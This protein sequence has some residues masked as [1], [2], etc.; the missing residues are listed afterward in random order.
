MA[1]SLSSWSNGGNAG[2]HRCRPGKEPVTVREP[3][4]ILVVP[5]SAIIHNFG[6]DS[7]RDVLEI[8]RNVGLN[9]LESRSRDDGND[10]EEVG[11]FPEASS[12]I[13]HGLRPGMAVGGS[14][15]ILPQIDAIC[16][17]C[18]KIW[19]LGH[20]LPNCSPPAVVPDPHDVFLWA[21]KKD[22]MTD[23]PPDGCTAIHLGSLEAGLRVLL[24]SVV[25]RLITKWNISLV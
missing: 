17:R 8:I 16:V 7:S 15:S 25:S 20:D 19:E 22:E 6:I 1:E 9:D 21:P 13:I 14:W 4:A 10:I 5:L 12:E 2:L 3:S 24:H 18:F 23:Q 11:S